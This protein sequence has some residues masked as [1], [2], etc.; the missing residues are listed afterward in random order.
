V[1]AESSAIV[2]RSAAL[3]ATTTAQSPKSR[4]P[5]GMH[6]K[7]TDET[8]RRASPGVGGRESSASAGLSTARLRDATPPTTPSTT[9]ALTAN[10]A[11]VWTSFATAA[12][13]EE[14]VTPRCARAE[15]RSA[16]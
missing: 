3:G 1:A 14:G 16:A 6:M 4:T 7:N 11:K 13:A 5:P 10:A 8:R 12:A 2:A 9:P 15:A